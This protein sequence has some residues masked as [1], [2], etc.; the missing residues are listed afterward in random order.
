MNLKNHAFSLIEL[1]TTVTIIVLLLFFGVKFYTEQK[2]QSNIR[3][4]Q[5]E[6]I[7]VLKYAKMAKTVDIGYHQFLYQMGYT[8]KGIITSIVGTGASG[9]APCC[10]NY[11]AL[12]HA[13]CT[14]NKGS[15]R[16]YQ[17]S[18]GESC[19]PGFICTNCELGVCPAG[20]GNCTCRG[21][22]AVESYTYYNCQNDSLNSATYNLQICN[23]GTYGETCETSLA[24]SVS[25]FP[26]FS[27]CPP[28]G[29]GWCNCNKFVVGAKSNFFAEE[30][31]LN[32]NNKLC[33]KK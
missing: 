16:T 12:G 33:I 30:I 11:P 10:S 9:T 14:K 20:G 4:A 18:T 15:V 2:E 3:I 21:E 31:T 26:S 6:M 1:L 5:S 23:D 32:H 19:G 24:P 8:P 28:G 29:G 22:Q 13:T 7:E 25:S 27:K 17:I